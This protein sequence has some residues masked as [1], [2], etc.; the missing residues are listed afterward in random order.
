MPELPEVE[1][2]RRTLEP[3]ICG[4]KIC[5]LR[6]FWEKTLVSWQGQAVADTVADQRIQRVGRRGKYLLIQL[7]QGWT[8]AAHLRMTGRFIYYPD[9]QEPDKHT[10]VIFNLTQGELHFHDV[11][12]FGRIQLLPTAALQTVFSPAKLGPEPFSADFSAAYLLQALARKKRPI[13]SVLLEQS[14][15]A[16]LGN[17]YADEALFLA[18]V[19]PQREAAALSE[20]ETVALHQAIQAVLTTG[21]E[22]RGTTLRD[23]RDANGEK[24]GFQDFLRVYGRGNCPCRRCGEKLVKLRLG[25]R[26]AVF[27]PACQ[28]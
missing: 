17:I 8:L 14:L 4:Q 26:A 25:G 12:K 24:G 11:R 13:K 28:R 15:V 27:C 18:G 16:G 20:A 2:I 19:H 23:Y 9:P 10:Q 3:L 6:L 5:G 7:E 22:Q 1:T 21:I